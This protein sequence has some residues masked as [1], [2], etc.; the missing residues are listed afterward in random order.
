MGLSKQ[1]AS[2][3]ES[4]RAE[5]LSTVCSRSQGGDKGREEGKKKKKKRGKAEPVDAK[6]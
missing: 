5:K 4:Q 3:M 6:V 1:A 2:E